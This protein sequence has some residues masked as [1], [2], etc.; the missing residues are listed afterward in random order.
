MNVRIYCGSLLAAS[1][2]F[3]ASN[4]R[5]ADSIF[6]LLPGIPGASLDATHVNWIDVNAMQFTAGKNP[7]AE[8][9]FSDLTIT[10]TIDNATPILAQDCAAGTYIPNAT[11]QATASNSLV[12]QIKLDNVW[13]TSDSHSAST[14]NTVENVTLRFGKISW[15]YQQ[16]TATSFDILY[17]KIPITV[18]ASGVQ[19]AGN[20]TMN[21][22]WTTS[23]GATY[24][25]LG[26]S[27]VDGPY[28]LVQSFVATNLGPVTITV[29]TTTNMFFF[30][31]QEMP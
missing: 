26:S 12:Y 7:G 25:I 14:T 18:G 13:V 5:A 20:G 11:L 19:N 6:L 29:P 24:N 23:G 28:T 2:L 21:L 27:Q 1:L 17:G 9:Q 30:R 16:N 22:A 31:V 10:K 4:S 15:S 8:P 3:S